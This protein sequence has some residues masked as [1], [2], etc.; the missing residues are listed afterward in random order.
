MIINFPLPQPIVNGPFQ[1]GITDPQWPVSPPEIILDDEAAKEQYAFERAGRIDPQNF[2]TVVTANVNV[3]TKESLCSLFKSLSSFVKAQIT[4]LPDDNH[5][6]V[7]KEIPKTWR[8]TITV[9][10]GSLLFITADGDDR[11]GIR[12][13][14]P[15]WLRTMP[16]VTGDTFDPSKTATDLI[17]LISSDHPYVN[18]SIARALSQGNWG[19][20]GIKEK[21]II[22]KTIDQGFSRPDRR[23]FL[24]FD[25]GIDN[26]SNSKD[27]ELDKF[28]YVTQS[29]GEPAWATNGAYL[30]WRKIRENLP[31]WEAFAN[32]EQEKMI[33]RKKDSGVP[34]SREVSGPSGMAPVYPNPK[35]KA[36]GPLTAHIRKVQ[37]RRPGTDLFGVAD[38]ERRFLRRGYPYFD[39]LET[40][41]DKIACGLLFLAFT[42]NLR[43]QF[44]WPVESWQTNPDF[45]EPGTGIDIMY[46]SGVLSNVSG[47]YYFCPP[48]FMNDKDAFLG[49]ALFKH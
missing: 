35:D 32:H 3:D 12:H 37:P 29:D 39:G 38:L 33:G 44:E 7:L 43:K 41:T 20:Q 25:D 28:V 22:V 45:P 17:F 10:L 23:E 15:R 21:R 14:K 40:G 16:K 5:I 19:Q 46:G 24:R 49:M 1:T 11:F 4:R 2:L 8:V 6:P 9:G 13:L 36:D 18:I 47:G 31:F 34:L 42:R 30:A 48:S 26:L 27:D